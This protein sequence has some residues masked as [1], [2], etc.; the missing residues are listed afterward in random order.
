M[1][2][3]IK[4]RGLCILF[5]NRSGDQSL[6]LPV[7]QRLYG[8]YEGFDGI[9]PSDLRQLPGQDRYLFL[10]AIVNI[11]LFMSNTGKI[12]GALI[13]KIDL[14]HS[15]AIEID[16]FVRTEY[17]GGTQFQD[18]VVGKGLDDQFGPDPI[19]VTYGNPYDGSLLWK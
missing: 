7:F 1:S 11:D 5:M 15:L 13:R 3:E 16:Q 18:P 9:T 4:R 14:R 19:Q 8:C 12:L 10:P 2:R 17:E 6:Y